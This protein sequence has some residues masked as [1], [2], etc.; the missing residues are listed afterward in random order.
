MTRQTKSRPTILPAFNRAINAVMNT[1]N[2]LINQLFAFNHQS[3][4]LRSMTIGVGFILL[5]LLFS[6]TTLPAAEYPKLVNNWVKVIASGDSQ[7]ILISTLAIIYTIFFNMTILRHLLALYVPFWLMQHVASIYLADIFEKEEKTAHTFIRQAAFGE[8]YNTIRIRQGKVVDEDLKSP[9]IQIGGP[10]YVVVELDSAV[11]FER[12][13]GTAHVIFPAAR[14]NLLNNKT[15]SAAAQEQYSSTIIQGFER[16]RQGIDLRDVIHKQE[17][18]A[19]SRDGIPVSA[20]DI[21]YSY[22]IY[23]GAN[24]VKSP[25]TPY[26]FDETAVLNLVYN[27]IRSVKL[28]EPPK[29]IQDWLEPL[30]AKIVGQVRAEMN[31][32]INKR[33]L[34]D[35]L[36]TT[37]RPEESSLEERKKDSDERMRVISGLDESSPSI[38][39]EPGA[40]QTNPSDPTYQ[41]ESPSP[42]L[43]FVPRSALTKMITD[44]FQKKA[45]QRG[46]QLNWIGVGTWDTPDSIIP[47]NHHEAW[48]ISRENFA[49]GNPTELQRIYENARQQ[50]ILRLIQEVPIRKLYIDLENFEISQQVVG[51][52]KEYLVL[53]ERA[54]ELYRRDSIPEDILN[55]ILEIERWI[56][57]DGFYSVGEEE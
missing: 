14:E 7:N 24:P 5:W 35:F 57:P 33:G 12:P 9:M 51:V 6:F 22:S 3:A 26:P 42:A 43:E 11:V 54:R 46:T 19:R 37:G 40:D 1:L 38:A 30:P 48:K 25:Q 10:G 13:D 50:E 47:K 39:T 28:D 52:L 4:L 45:P 17:I 18:T 29:R 16:I 23:R 15:S 34:G 21:Q 27:E 55:A 20:K 53:L 49:R 31:A 36:A 56:Y 41:M 44:S 32:F 8:S 2:R